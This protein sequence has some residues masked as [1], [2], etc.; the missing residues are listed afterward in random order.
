MD[1]SNL[2]DPSIDL[3]LYGDTNRKHRLPKE[4]FHGNP[5][6]WSRSMSERRVRK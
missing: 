5:K 2:V 3:L 4:E 6:L 1:Y